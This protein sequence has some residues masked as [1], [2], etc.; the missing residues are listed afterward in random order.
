MPERTLIIPDLHQRVHILR[1]A[2]ETP[3]W[4]RAVVLGDLFD[5]FQPTISSGDMAGQVMDVKQKYGEDV[6]FLVG[7]HDLPYYFAAPICRRHQSPHLARLIYGCSGYSNNKAEE[8]SKVLDDDFIYSCRLLAY[9]NG[10]LLS[11]GGVLPQDLSPAPGLSD[12]DVLYNLTE[13]AF[14]LWR[15]FRNPTSSRHPFFRV[16]TSRGGPASTGGL[17]WCDWNVDFFDGLPWPQIV[18]HTMDRH[19]RRNN[20]SFCLDTGIHWAILSDDSME[21]YERGK[22]LVETKEVNKEPREE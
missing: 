7:N 11:H 14:N 12:G 4:S 6:L 17:L 3:D 9:R 2:L 18:G 13:E 1:E 16:G 21:I 10:F 20:R 15:D 8:I 19:V 22:G 5:D